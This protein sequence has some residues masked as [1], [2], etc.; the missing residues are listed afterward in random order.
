MENRYYSF[1]LKAGAFV[2]KEQHPMVSLPEAISQHLHLLLLTHFNENKYDS[3]FGNAIWE[4]EFE[5]IH[6]NNPVREHIRQSIH[7]NI[8][9][10]E[11]R[12]EQVKTDIQIWQETLLNASQQRLHE[13]VDIRVSA[14]IVKTREPFRYEEHFYIA[15]LAQDQ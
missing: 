6:N 9:R 5:P 14:V 10:Y 7:K 13:R 11:P 2:R 3:A 12:I 1:P 4:N 8:I 15:P